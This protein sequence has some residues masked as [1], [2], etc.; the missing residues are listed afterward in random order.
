MQRANDLAES[1]RL[2]I[3]YLDMSRVMTL[4]WYCQA[5]LPH[6]SALQWHGTVP[7]EKAAT[8][9]YWY[10]LCKISKELRGT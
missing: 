8:S 10:C 6:A 7:F 9:S 3:Y 5:L 4:A 1:G 2:L